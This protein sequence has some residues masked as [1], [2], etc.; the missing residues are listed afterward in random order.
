MAVLA[1]V[2][3]IVL[4]RFQA[5][6]ALVCVRPELV[7]VELETPADVTEIP[8]EL[9]DAWAELKK[10]GFVL[11]GTHSEKV[12]LGPARL[13][14]DGKHPEHPVIASLTTNRDEQDELIFV[15]QSDRGFVVTAN[16]RRL[17]TEVPGA[18]LAGG[19]E[20]ASPERLLK[21]HLRRVPEIGTAK[22]LGTLEDRVVAARDWYSRSGKP[23]LRQQHAVGLLWTLGALGMVAAAL[24]RL[25]S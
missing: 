22:V 13:F 14:L 12:P 2:G 19:L 17:A 15:T 24:F 21:A 23:E 1:L 3:A 9:E 16:Y 25:L 6:R 10:L 18:Y 8:P 4:L 5:W 7:K 11:L 20:G